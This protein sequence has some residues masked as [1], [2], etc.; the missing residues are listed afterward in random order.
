MN[1]V[2]LVASWFTPTVLFCVLNLMIGT[3]F[4]TSSLKPPKQQGKLA[5]HDGDRQ[6]Q[7]LRVPSLFERVKSINLSRYYTEQSDP[8]HYAVAGQHQHQQQEKLGGHDDEQPPQLVR[9]PSFFERVKSINLS[10]YR[11]EQ[12]DP[13]HHAVPAEEQEVHQQEPEYETE[14]HHHVTRSKS[15]T[16]TQATA[17]AAVRVLKKCASEKVGKGEEEVEADPRRPATTRERT[18]ASG[19]EDEAVDAKADDFINRF[20]QQLKLQRLDSIL[21]Y[22]EMLNRGTGR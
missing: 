1:G 20:R 4:I 14:E 22:R 15:D 13:A 7:L 16:V 2:E 6:P 9:V 8:V 19:R 11:A 21:R 10:R 5:G 12:S 18:A 3:I 17:T